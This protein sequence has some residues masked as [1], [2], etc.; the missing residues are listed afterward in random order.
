MPENMPFS[1]LHEDKVRGLVA[2]AA[3]TALER[4][5]YKLAV[6]QVPYSRLYAWIHSGQLDVA[7]AVLNSGDRGT[8]AHYSKPIVVEY[9]V[10]LVPKGKP[11]RFNRAEDLVDRRVGAQPGFLYPGLD[12]LNLPLVRERNLAASITNLAEGHLEGTLVG[13]ITGAYAADQLGVAHRLETLPHASEAIPLGVAF[14]KS[15]FVPA[16]V[17]AFEAVMT[18]LQAGPEWQPLLAE[19]SAKPYIR[20]WPLIGR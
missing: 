14:S 19:S 12:H 6:R 15:A 10:I 8:Q 3:M 18:N 17:R 11:F 4:M 13:S 16:D 1:G 20:D 2:R 9:T 5:A 7:V